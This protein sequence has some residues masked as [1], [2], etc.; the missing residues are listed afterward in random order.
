MGFDH[1]Y[2]ATGYF[3]DQGAYWM[4]A[5]GLI[6]LLFFCYKMGV[7]KSIVFHLIAFPLVLNRWYWL[8]DK[9]REA[10]Q[11]PVAA[12]TLLV[13]LVLYIAFAFALSKKDW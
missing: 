2:H 13:A 10:N 9:T 8:T 4:Y 1:F 11:L 12:F 7:I 5:I 6:S 3:W